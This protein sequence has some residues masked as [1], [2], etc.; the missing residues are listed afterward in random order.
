MVLSGG[1][2][3]T[4]RQFCCDDLLKFANVNVDHLTETV[5]A[6]SVPLQMSYAD[7]HPCVVILSFGVDA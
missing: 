7:A 2:M 6:L 1:I 5:R 4:I 3:T